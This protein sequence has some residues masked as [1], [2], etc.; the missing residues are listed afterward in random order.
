M[1]LYGKKAVVYGAGRSGLSAWQLI[2]EHGGRAVIYD[3]DP[4]KS[5]ATSSKRVFAD[6]DLIVL[7]PG[8]PPTKD[9]V[10]DARLE[11]KRV[12]SELELASSFSSFCRAEQIAVTGTNGKTTA[13][14]LIDAMLK[15]AGKRSYAV[16]NIGTAFSAIADRLDALETA[17]IEAS[18]FQLETSVSFSPDIAVMLNITPDHLAPD[19][20]VMLNIT[21]DHLDR[22]GSMERYIGAKARIF[23]SQSE[24]DTAVYNADDE[25]V[26]ELLPVMRARAVPFSMTRPVD[27]A[28]ISSGFICYKGEPVVETADIDLAGRELEDALAAT[29]AA[30]SAGAGLYAVAS[31][32]QSFRRPPYRRSPGAVVDGI[33][34]V[35][36]SKATNIGSVLSAVEGLGENGVLILGGARGSEDFSELFAALP[37]SVKGAVLVGENADDIAKAAREAGFFGIVRSD[38]LEE[39][40]ADAVDLAKELGCSTVLFS[41][42]SKSY[43]AFTSYEERG[44][45]FDAAAAA[46]AAAKK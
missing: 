11:G 37:P 2:R 45:A 4:S 41:P 38:T 15:A 19:I 36:D 22:H 30:A 44:R 21:P 3:D 17:V 25:R 33:R 1:D 18:S 26:A 10:L 16:G 40:C 14:M 31:A 13:V 7:S 29:A 9:V 8:V 35:N 20:A 12:M 46:L 23:L 28:Y 42:S 39:A 5:H 24:C 27:G 6:C 32:L 43:D 34:L